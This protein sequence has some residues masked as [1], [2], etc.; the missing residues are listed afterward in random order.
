MKQLTIMMDDKVGA[1]AD[2]SYLLG[3]AKVNIESVSAEVYS[4][5]VVINLT[6]KDDEKAGEVLSKNGYAVLK[7]DVLVIK[8]KDEPGA[9]SEISN[10]LKKA[11]INVESL[12]ILTR[13]NGYSLDV[14]KVDKPRAARKLLA[15]C[16]LA[17]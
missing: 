2:I 17:C 7:S 3:K 11:N 4:G 16:L 12:F 15:D 1:L 5:K 14:F 13:G 8:V 10:R 6:V 9:L